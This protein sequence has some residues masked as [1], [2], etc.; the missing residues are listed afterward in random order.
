MS[1]RC[2][3]CNTN[4]SSCDAKRLYQGLPCCKTCHHD[5]PSEAM[6]REPRR[7]ESTS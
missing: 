3:N 6:T 4:Q 2:D 5:R 1:D 7:P